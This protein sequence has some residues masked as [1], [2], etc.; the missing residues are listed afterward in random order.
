MA[1]RLDTQ[2]IHIDTIT[3]KIKYTGKIGEDLFQTEEDAIHFL[4]EHRKLTFKNQI[5]FSA[6]IGMTFINRSIFL[7]IS[8][9]VQ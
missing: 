7:L 1:I 6:L 3:G 5:R 4:K 9:K 8:T 2:L